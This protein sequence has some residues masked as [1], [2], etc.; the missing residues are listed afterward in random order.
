MCS[1]FDRLN[2]L[3]DFGA[4]HRGRESMGHSAL[5][6]ILAGLYTIKSKV[7][8]TLKIIASYVFQRG[9]RFLGSCAS[10]EFDA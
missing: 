10:Q 9:A 2:P 3:L 4:G 6:E 8:P 1:G 7:P 5:T